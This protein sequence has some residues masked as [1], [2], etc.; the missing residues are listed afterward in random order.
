MPEPVCVMELGMY[1]KATEPFSSAHV[2]NTTLQSVSLYVYPVSLLH[3]N[4]IG[5][6]FLAEQLLA[7]EK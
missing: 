1:I 7:Y 6:I 5:G 3:N 2:I 4:M